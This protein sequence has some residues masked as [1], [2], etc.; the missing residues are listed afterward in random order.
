MASSNEPNNNKN[1]INLTL[2]LKVIVVLLLLV[3]AAML[4]LWKPWEDTPGAADRTVQVT[5][6]AKVS[7]EPDEFVFYPTYSF[8][9]TDKAAALAELNKKSDAIVAEL[10]KLGVPDSKIKTNSDGYERGL[11]LPDKTDTGTT[12]NLSLI[13]TLNKKDLAQKV[14]DYIVTTNPT[15]PV[16]PQVTF[17]ENKQK[18]LESDA[19]EEATKDAR[20]KAEQSAKNLGY[21]I[22]KV[23]TVNDGTGFGPVQPLMSRNMELD[24]TISDSKLSLQPGEN[25]LNYSV[26]VTY[27]IK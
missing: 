3:I 9:N 10:K 18:Q 15:G 2:N 17:S 21:S 23:K 19:R 8:V 27:F 20:K 25:D 7:A 26:T 16:S 1:Q 6:Q 24:A 12:Y 22:G 13:V 5:G 14:Q 4:A 11:Y